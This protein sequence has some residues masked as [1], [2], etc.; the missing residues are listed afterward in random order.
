MAAYQSMEERCGAILSQTIVQTQ[1][2]FCALPATL[3]LLVL[4]LAYATINTPLTV[5]G[6]CWTL[7]SK[8]STSFLPYF[9]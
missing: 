4:L 8:Y 5:Q 2:R 7:L 9:L 6:A 3:L 1:K